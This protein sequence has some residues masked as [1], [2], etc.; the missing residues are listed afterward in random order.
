MTASGL[1]AAL[2]YASPTPTKPSIGRPTAAVGRSP[3]PLGWQL[4]P[5]KIME[6]Q[7]KTARQGSRRAVFNVG[8]SGSRWPGLAVDQ[9]TE[10]GTSVEVRI[11]WL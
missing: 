7:K 1:K 4:S 5:R 10:T 11:A 2:A 3:Q 8:R 9:A 6:A